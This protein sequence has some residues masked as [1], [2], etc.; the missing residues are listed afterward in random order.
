M[1]QRWLCGSFQIDHIIAEQ[2][3]GATVLE[4]LALACTHCNK[5]KRP[6]V[7]G[8]DPQAGEVTRLFHP[9]R[10][11]WKDHFRWDGVELLGTTAIGRATVHVLNINA[12]LYIAIR[13]QLA[14]K[15]HFP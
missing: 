10:D 5:Y 1:Q 11:R 7:A 8:I 4:N 2:H 6:N 14:E 12:P 9:R 3:G 13:N 15:G